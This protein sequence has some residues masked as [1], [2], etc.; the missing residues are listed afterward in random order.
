MNLKYRSSYLKQY[1]RQEITREIT[2]R[3]I[4]TMRRI[5]MRRVQVLKRE[6]K[7]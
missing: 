5:K 1:K 6:E 4:I 7:K 3:K 2:C